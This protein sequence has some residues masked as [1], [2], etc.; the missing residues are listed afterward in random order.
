[1][2]ELYIVPNEQSYTKDQ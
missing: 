1:M 2:I